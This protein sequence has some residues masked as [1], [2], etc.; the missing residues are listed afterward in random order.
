MKMG[1]GVEDLFF[2]CWWEIFGD[3]L[4]VSDVLMRDAGVLMVWTVFVVSSPSKKIR[5][6]LRCSSCVVVLFSEKQ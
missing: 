6:R 1:L 4:G 5:F 2:F 3:I